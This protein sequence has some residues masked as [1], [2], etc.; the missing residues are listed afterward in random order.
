MIVCTPIKNNSALPPF[1][2]KTNTRISSFCVSN[3]DILSV[4]NS[5]D[6]SKSHG[7]DNVSVE[8]QKFVV[9]QLLYP[10]KLHLRNHLKGIFPEIW[11]KPNVV[12][13][14]KKEDN[15]LIK[16]YHPIS[17]L[18][19]FVKIF[20]RIIYNSLFI[21]VLKSDKL[22][23]DDQIFQVWSYLNS[24]I[25]IKLP[26]SQQEHVQIFPL[27]SP[28]KTWALPFNFTLERDPKNIFYYQCDVENY[29][30]QVFNFVIW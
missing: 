14:H 13:V 16:N 24:L 3:K 9:I 30:Y 11:K 5:L 7:H 1:L 2:Y 4:I 19:I 15:T 17:L 12:P 28:S 6:S 29:T 8:C 21:K 26:F 18:P 22:S 23:G 27:P 20:G 10:W 25:I